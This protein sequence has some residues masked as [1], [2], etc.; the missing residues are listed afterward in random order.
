MDTTTEARLSRLERSVAHWKAA[1][2]AAVAVAV[3]ALAVVA[4][5]PGEAAAPAAG[6]AGVADELRAKR[7]I[8][9]DD[10]GE[11]TIEMKSTPLGGGEIGVLKP[12]QKRSLS[13]QPDAIL[14]GDLRP[15]RVS[16]QLNADSLDGGGSLT[17]NNPDNRLVFSAGNDRGDGRMSIMDANGKATFKAP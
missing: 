3:A 8:V 16:F 7:I 4:A 5:R 2:I 12:G 15:E 6:K 9:V 14:C 1:C 17:L 13:L 11:T 10:R